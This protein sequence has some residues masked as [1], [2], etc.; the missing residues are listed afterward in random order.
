MA[1]KKHGVHFDV[2]ATNATD[3]ALMAVENN[4]KG[5]NRAAESVGRVLQGAFIATAAIAAGK[6]FATAAIE[7]E[8]A[9]KRLDAVLKATGHSAG[10]TKDELDGMADA[11]AESTQFD[12]ESLRNASAQLLKFGNI[13]GETFRQAIKLSADLAAFMGTDIVSAVQAVGKALTAPTEGT[14]A[15]E[16][17]IGKFNPAAKEMIKT[18]E[19]QGRQAAAQ[20]AV[21]DLLKGKI[22]GTAEALNTGLSK[23]AGDAKKQWNEMLEAIGKT[24]PFQKVAKSGL[25]FIEQ[26]FRDIKHI[27]E[28]GDW[29][30]KALAIMAFAGGWR[31][32]K[33][34]PPAPDAVNEVK[35]KVR[36]V[37]DPAKMDDPLP[38]ISEADWKG[39]KDYFAFLDKKRAEAKQQKEKDDREY[40]QLAQRQVD[41]EEQAAKETAEA[42]DHWGKIQ[43]DQEKKR[44]EDRAEMWKQVFDTIDREQDEAIEEGRVYLEGLEEEAKKAAESAKE[45]GY[46]FQSAFEDAVLEGKNLW[47]VV[48]GLGKDIG[49]IMMREG[50]TKPFGAAL[51]DAVKGSDIGGGIGDWFK[52]LFKAEGGPVMA[53]EPYIVG[54]RG[55]EVMVPG[56]SGSIIPNDALRRGGE[57]SGGISIGYLDMRGASVEA[58]ARLERMLARVN[59]SVESRAL[60]VMRAAS[61]RGA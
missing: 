59:A 54:E 58:V 51:T 21:L 40:E 39:W 6:A 32:M 13:H 19:E 15:L 20:A 31:G 11:L 43:L 36:G 44:N 45:L 42:W 26:S 24:E 18:L 33:L 52:G 8:Q 55:P 49:R 23:S 57:S 22:G 9:S 50:I 5:I 61:V 28:S 25:S 46:A 30:E 35:G 4:L 60:G 56:V 29:V 34:T 37:V 7:A 17:Q 27:V 41:M 1:V 38:P 10:L 12:D 16:K 53:G 3:R 47:D 48:K 2:T 14:G